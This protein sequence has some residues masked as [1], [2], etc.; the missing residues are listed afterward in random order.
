[1]SLHVEQHG[2][3]D[4]VPLVLVHGAPDTC[5]TWYRL[6]PHLH[7]KRI[8]LY[9]RRGYGR[10][11]ELPPATSMRDH[12]DDLLAVVAECSRPP[13]VV[14]HSFGAN[15]TM[16]AASLRP[17]AFA[18]LGLWEPPTVWVDWWPQRTKD[19]NAEVAASADPAM[20]IEEMLRRMLGDKAWE[21][22]PAETRDRR[23][24]EGKA[25]QGD[26][27]SALVAPF[28]FAE[29]TVPA[30]VGSGTD[31]SPEHLHGAK[32]LAGQLPHG[33]LYVVQGAGHYANRTHPEAYARFVD[34][35]VALAPVS[36]G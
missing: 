15:V 28:G 18:A 35:A 10:S 17:A 8:V 24:A 23:R 5:R 1:M 9:D 33:H 21:A 32:W 7:G 12:A 6:M 26:M 13:V 3:D 19:Y 34:A 31:T 11:A 4:G 30:V 29:V 36:P 16:L 25:Y 14:A 2:P 22:L 27:A 20:T